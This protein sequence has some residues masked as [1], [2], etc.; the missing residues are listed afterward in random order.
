MEISRGF[1]ASVQE[2]DTSGLP[3][4]DQCGKPGEE[5][6][7]DERYPGLFV[8]LWPVAGG[9]NGGPVA[10]P[11]LTLTA[12]PAIRY[13]ETCRMA[14]SA[15]NVMGSSPGRRWQRTCGTVPVA[16]RRQSTCS[17]RRTGWK[18]SPSSRRRAPVRLERIGR[19]RMRF[20]PSGRRASLVDAEV[21]ELR[22]L[23]RVNDVQRDLSLADAE[24]EIR[25]VMR[26]KARRRMS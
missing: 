22:R 4:P 9:R 7:I 23:R 3:H 15:F 8:V 16:V 6:S 20:A 2:L 19:P 24:V 11:N 25:S 1:L 21:V 18:W 26:T 10:R 12:E 13:P 14:G 5:R 17:V